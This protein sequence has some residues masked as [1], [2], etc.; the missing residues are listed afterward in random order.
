MLIIKISVIKIDLN[1]IAEVCLHVNYPII[2]IVDWFYAAF[3]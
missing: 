2:V 1:L 3:S